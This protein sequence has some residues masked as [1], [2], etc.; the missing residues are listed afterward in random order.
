[1]ESKLGEIERLTKELRLA[2]TLANCTPA[3]TPPPSNE[4]SPLE[5]TLFAQWKAN[6]HP[7]V[8]GGLK[9]L[10]TSYQSCSAATVAA[11]SSATP[12]VAGISIVGT[13]KDGVGSKREITNLS[14]FL[15]SH[16]YLKNYS[17]PSGAGCFDIKAKPLIYDYGGKPYATASDSSSFDLFKD[18][19][20]GTAV[21]GIDCSAFVYV[22]LA[23]AGLKLKS[24]GT[25]L[26]R[27]A[28]GISSYMLGDPVGSKLNCLVHAG[29]ATNS[30]IKPGDVISKPGHVFLV[31]TV[32][33]DP[34]GI[35]GIK[36]ADKCTLSNIS[37]SKFDFTI[38]QSSNSKNGIGIHRT[39]ASDF[40]KETSMGDGLRAH[41]VNAC[42]AKF[43]QTTSSKV[44]G[45]SIVRHSGTSACRANAI[46]MERESCVAS[47]EATTAVAN[48]PTEI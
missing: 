5:T 43:G 35:A 10:A 46:K 25:L 32:G 6:R 48:L 37:I 15:K 34:F 23:S 4:P 20:T 28:Q 17:K 11:V 40:L 29:F 14:S 19:G 21:L 7:A 18:E 22:A 38:L 26:A 42:K 36:S 44:S 8:Y 47:C 39:K 9:A 3:A 12:D 31:E 41:A 24:S 30:S 2:G 16:V 1:I 27:G 13:H 33:A 45:L